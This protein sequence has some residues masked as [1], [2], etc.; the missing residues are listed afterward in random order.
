[1][2]VL[3]PQM[4][5]NVHDLMVDLVAASFSAFVPGSTSSPETDLPS[6]GP[7][8]AWLTPSHHSTQPSA[9]GSGFPVFTAFH[10]DGN[11]LCICT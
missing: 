9:I 6:P 3:S 1:M 10:L 11:Y 8:G 5:W 2:A 4:F 7:H